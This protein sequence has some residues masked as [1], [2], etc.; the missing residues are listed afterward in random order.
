MRYAEVRDS[1]QSGD[2]LAWRGESLISRL[3]RHWT[4]SPWSHVGVAWRFRG[5]LF[6]LE[7]REGRGV[8]I[9]A[10]SHALPFH[11][12]NTGVKWTDAAEALA[13]AQLGKPYSYSDF[14]RAG[15]GLKLNDPTGD[16][17][18][19]YAAF[20]IAAADPHRNHYPAT[21]TPGKLVEHFLL[22]GATLKGIQA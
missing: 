17:C 5:R 14:V 9:R 3:I 12:I 20:V 6:V 19:E 8:T 18:S 2:L 16:I 15:L 21:P 4:A 10:A 1:I 11:H 13:L 22:E 7:A